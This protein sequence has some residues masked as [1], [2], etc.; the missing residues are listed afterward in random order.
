[1]KRI[2]LFLAIVSLLAGC[3]KEVLPE[4]VVLNWHTLSLYVGDSSTL[5]ATVTPANATNPGLSWS[6]TQPSV[7]TVD[8]E[9]KVTALSEGQAIIMVTTLSGAKSDACNVTVSKKAAPDPGHDDTV[10]GVTVTPATLEVAEGLTAQLKATVTPASASQEVEW[11]SQNSEIATVDENGLVTGVA[12]G[13]TKIYA[14]C[15]ANHDKQGFCEV[16]VTQDATLRGISFNV[17]EITLAIGQVYTMTVVYSPEYA[18]NKKVNWTSG[19]TAVASVTSDGKVT[20]VSEGITTVTATSEESGFTA[21]CNVIVSKTGGVKVYYTIY[22]VKVP[23][24]V[25]GEPDPRTGTFEEISK[26]AE[27]NPVKV[28]GTEGADLYSVENLMNNDG[29]YYNYLCKNRKP[30]YKV[31]KDGTPNYYNLAVQ[32]GTV[33]VINNPTDSKQIYV[34]IIKPDG[35]T[36]TSE[37]KGGFFK[38]SGSRTYLDWAPNG[39]LY[40]VGNVKDAFEE[41]WLA[42]YKYLPGG[43]WEETLIAK[44]VAVHDFDISAEGDKYILGVND[45]EKVLYKNGVLDSVIENNTEVRNINQALHVTG[46]HVYAAIYYINKHQVVEY[47]DGKPIRT[48]EVPRANYNPHHPLH[49]TSSGDIYLVTYECI[50]KNDSI[51]YTCEEDRI[52]NHFCVGE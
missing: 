23:L 44:D 6:S 2:V 29:N 33:A 32:N 8:Q 51:L 12:K 17:T 46:G 50:Y 49:V 35:T 19:N 16:T 26:Y 1:M 24:Y 4:A 30:L 38:N 39:E 48:L 18:A 7:A 41:E 31:P 14:R 5:E 40:A 45:G 27:N 9:G 13:T 43:E 10:E 34:Y 21:S 47:C 52:F 28:M 22:G 3:K 20:G 37:I 15:K 11:A 42:M 36:E 25:N